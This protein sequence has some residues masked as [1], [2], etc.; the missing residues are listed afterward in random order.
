MSAGLGLALHNKKKSAYTQ[1]QNAAGQL[2]LKYRPMTPES[3]VIRAEEYQRS[4][5]EYADALARHSQ[6]LAHIK[7]DMEDV[8][9]RLDALTGGQSYLQWEQAQQEALQQ[10][11]Q[12]SDSLRQLRQAEAVCQALSRPETLP[13]PPEERDTLTWSEDETRNLLAAAEAEYRQLQLQL[14]RCH[15]QME[16]LGQEDALRAE[17]AAV[18]QRLDALNKTFAALELAQQTAAQASAQLQ[19][20]FAPKLSKRA[21]ELF[22]RLTGQR[23]DRLTLAEDLSVMVGARQED[24]LRNDLWRS[25]GTVD[26]LY[27]ALRL[28]VAEELTPNAPLILDDALVRFDDRR[29][30]AAMKILAEQ[31]QD[32][33]V[34]LFTCQGRETKYL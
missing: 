2:L 16:S 22:S 32:K 31:A 10:H 33:Q 6:A 3:W 11:R 17:L 9:R 28:A 5:T 27:L 13:A 34:I 24:T 8:N 18:E 30:E 12:L 21:Q 19:R 20:H 25:D 4:R 7:A 1:A 23:Y 26:Q 29:L 14:G 15:G